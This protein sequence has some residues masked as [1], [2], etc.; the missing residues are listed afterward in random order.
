MKLD[1]RIARLAAS[2]TKSSAKRR[3][4]AERITRCLR[5]ISRAQKITAR[6]LK[7]LRKT[8][9][10]LI[11]RQNDSL[12]RNRRRRKRRNAKG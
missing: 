8:M 11:K 1:K 7:E 10:A 2:L 12:R 6:K 9:D 3:A 4:R 5:E